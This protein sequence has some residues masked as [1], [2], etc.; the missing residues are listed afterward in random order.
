MTN[1]KKIKI[2]NLGV[3]LATSGS[4]TDHHIPYSSFFCNCFNLYSTPAF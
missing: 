4:A 3:P 2:K 1:N